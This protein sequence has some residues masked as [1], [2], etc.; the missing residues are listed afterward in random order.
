MSD[1]FRFLILRLAELNPCQNLQRVVAV[2]WIRPGNLAYPD[3][4]LCCILAEHVSI[5]WIQK[6][7]WMVH[8][9]QVGERKNRSHLPTILVEMSP[10]F[11]FPH[12]RMFRTIPDEFN[13]SVW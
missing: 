9:M 6:W 2:A 11:I 10:V 4:A 13:C 3:R 8:R 7:R 1:W 12:L 5:R